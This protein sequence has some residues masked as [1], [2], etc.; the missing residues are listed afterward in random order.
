MNGLVKI[1]DRW[2]ASAVADMI[3]NNRK[4]IRCLCQKCKEVC[5]LDPYSGSLQAHLLM[6]NFMDNYTRWIS[7]DDEDVDGA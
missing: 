4:E 5:L 1:V 3:Q 2:M 6:H 7:E